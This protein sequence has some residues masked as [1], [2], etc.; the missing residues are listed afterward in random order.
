MHVLLGI[1]MAALSVTA[2]GSLVLLRR[3][4]DPRALL[5][6][7][8]SALWAAT[9]GL[10][11]WSLGP[12]PL[13]F[14]LPTL[15]ALLATA[16]SLVCPFLLRALDRTLREL[17]RSESLHWNSMETVRALADLSALSALD[18][19]TRL[20]RLLEI[21]CELLGLEIGFYSRLEGER[22]TVA[23]LRAPAGFPLA[24]GQSHRVDTIWCRAVLE[25]GRPFDLPDVSASGFADPAAR[26]SFPFRA[27]IGSAVRRDGVVCGSL[28]FA[29]AA[30]RRERFGA[31]E[32]DLLTLLTRWLGRE[33]ERR[34]AAPVLR[35]AGASAPAP[36]PAPRPPRQLAPGWRTLRV[37]RREP[38]ARRP[39]APSQRRAA[40]AGILDLNAALS[41]LERR[42]RRAAGRGIALELALTP[43]L[44]PAR[45][46]RLPLER[47]VLSLV[48]AAAQAL[49]DGGR[50]QVSSA[51]VD[52]G[53]SA[54]GV[55]PTV[56]PDRYVT[57]VVRAAGVRVEADALEDAFETRGA[58]QPA[59][60]DLYPPSLPALYRLLQRQGGDLSIYV[61]RGRSVSFTVFLPCVPAAR[62][63]GRAVAPA[64]A[65]PPA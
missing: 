7:A 17:D 56:A 32:K 59:A 54:P 6:T 60:A 42:L 9:W 4:G 36:V 30:P 39:A 28:A 34:G 16:A 1:S 47:V 26:E 50:I 46:P 11:L 2:A 49:P 18:L 10:A 23:A 24:R 37:P 35:E 20:A 25:A 53:A 41:R 57:V 3:R 14:D 51:G 8:A 43:D 12:R 61:E 48:R 21:G 64:T 52:M 38:A 45:D 55:L 19:E 31:T 29:A 22:C 40:L 15:A 62:T 27:Y 33:L 44:P 63:R 13:R 58:E 5:L 65:P